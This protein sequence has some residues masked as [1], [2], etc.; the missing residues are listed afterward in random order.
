MID[1]T[2]T[3]GP[4]Q[5]VLTWDKGKLTIAG[6]ERI[7]HGIEAAMLEGLGYQPGLGGVVQTIDPRNELHMIALIQLLQSGL[8]YEVSVRTL[9]TLPTLPYDPTW[10]WT[11]AQKQTINFLQHSRPFPGAE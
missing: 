4:D 3:S 7:Q 2:I 6:S 11:E 1:V 10:R 5:A 9:P 8:M